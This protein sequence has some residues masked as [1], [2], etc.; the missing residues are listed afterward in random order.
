MTGECGERPARSRVPDARGPVMGGGDDA[1]AIG[2]ERGTQDAL[3]V[4]GEDGELL[5]VAASQMRAVWS[6]E[7]VTMRRPSGENAAEKTRSPWPESTASCLA[8]AASQTR[9]VLS[10]E[11]VTMRRPSGEN[12]AQ[13]T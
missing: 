6:S 13:M 12:S 2:R 4:A 5:A 3:V 9:A 1:P 10:A 11:A 7:A 8:V